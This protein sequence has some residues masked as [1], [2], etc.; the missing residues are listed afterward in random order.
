[1]SRQ[2]GLEVGRP[3]YVVQF[4]DREGYFSSCLGRTEDEVREKSRGRTQKTFTA[5]SLPFAGTW[6]GEAPDVSLPSDFREAL[7]SVDRAVDE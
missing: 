2:D 3:F 1:M 5:C 6:K 4:F 7:A